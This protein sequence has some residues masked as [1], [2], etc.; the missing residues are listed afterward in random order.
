MVCRRHCGGRNPTVFHLL[1][2]RFREMTGTVELDNVEEEF[3]CTKEHMGLIKDKAT[4]ITE[5]F[6][7]TKS[8]QEEIVREMFDNTENKD[9][10]VFTDGL[11]L[12]NP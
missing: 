3:K 2:S 9:V 10:L 11:A 7:N 1:M 5:E 12:D 8:K 6:Q 4:V